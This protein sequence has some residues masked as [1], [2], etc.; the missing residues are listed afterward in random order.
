MDQPAQIVSKSPPLVAINIRPQPSHQKLS[1]IPLILVVVLVFVVV[2]V[3]AFWLGRSS[4]EPKI[5]A[6]PTPTAVVS[7]PNIFSELTLGWNDYLNDQYGFSLKYPKGW[8]INSEKPNVEIASVPLSQYLHGVGT[9]PKGAAWISVIMVDEEGIVGEERIEV[10]PNSVII[11][12]NF[13]KSGLKR[14][15]KIRGGYW[16]DDPNENI[17]KGVF[18]QIL[19]TFQFLE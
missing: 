1:K 11:F 14:I 5:V 15:Y 7:K 9:P 3:S 16:E 19:S 17:Y 10:G 12:H 6:Q 13:Y 8:R 18:N 4:G 2:G